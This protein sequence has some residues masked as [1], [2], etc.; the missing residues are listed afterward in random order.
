MIPDFRDEELF[1]VEKDARTNGLVGITYG[2][3]FDRAYTEATKHGATVN[4]INNQ[5]TLLDIAEP[6]WDRMQDLPPLREGQA[7]TLASIVAA[8]RGHVIEPTGNGKTFIITA[9]CHLYDKINILVSAPNVDTFREMIERIQK[10]CPGERINMLGGGKKKVHRDARIAVCTNSSAHHVPS[11]W[12]DLVLYDE[13]HTVGAPTVFPKFGVFLKSVMIGLTASPKGR[14]DKS[15][16]CTEAIFG[17]VIR[18]VTYQEAVR[19]GNIADIEVRTVHCDMDDIDFP[20]DIDK[21][22]FGYWLN[23]SRN[24]LLI[25]AALDTF[26]KDEQVLF[27]VNRVEHALAMR[28]FLPN[29]PIAHGPISQ[30]RWDDMTKLGLTQHTTLEVMNGVDTDQLK[31]DFMA[32]NIPWVIAT[33]KWKQGVDTVNLGG[34]V[35]MDGAANDI[36]SIQIPGRLSRKGHDGMKQVG[37][38]IDSYDDFGDM[39]LR[40]S[41]KRMTK[42]EEMGWKIVDI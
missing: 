41:N 19:L 23:H 12:P 14:S 13:A 2:G 32:G 3:L 16:L 8:Y 7:Q 11:D 6:D 39:Y 5:H 36:L 31:K 20:K 24:A 35:R 38:L 27:M 10:T 30:D 17:G 15:D 9:M 21:E 42:Y 29:I 34:L 40:R 26:K 28:R 25:K 33:Y 37:V 22:R 4:V 1:S 18:K